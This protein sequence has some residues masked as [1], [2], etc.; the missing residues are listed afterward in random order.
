M[1]G[2]KVWRILVNVGMARCTRSSPTVMKDTN[3]HLIAMTERDMAGAAVSS[4]CRTRLTEAAQSAHVAANLVGPFLSFLVLL[5]L[6]D[7]GFGL[8]HGGSSS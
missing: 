8:L 1:G 5:D 7:G 2:A 6:L 4:I 3:Q